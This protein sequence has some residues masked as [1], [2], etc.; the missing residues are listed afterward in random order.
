M[1]YLKINYEEV[2]ALRGLPHMQQLLYLCGIKPFVDYRTG[3][4]G[5]KR[6]ISYQS[7]S[8]VL[9]IEPHS[10]IQSGSP[11]KSQLRR[12]LKGLERAGV[13]KIQSDDYSLI[14]NCLLLS[15]G[16]SVP[17]KPVIK[18]SRE[19]VQGITSEVD[20]KSTT[21]K[22][23]EAKPVITKPGQ[24]VI[25]LCSNNN[26]LFL[27]SKQ[28][29]E[30]WKLYPLKK[31]KQKTWE[32][33]Q[34]MQPTDEQ[35]TCILVALEKQVTAHNHLTAQGQWVPGWKFPPNWLAQHCWEDEINTDTLQESKHANDQKRHTAT[36]PV[37]SFWDSCK[38][39][40]EFIGSDNSNIV[41]IGGFRKTEKSH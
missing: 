36:Q 8:E 14:F 13:I 16:Q 21:Y 18:P 6:K 29:E 24:P 12:A 37:D 20:L 33:F 2:S 28:C 27:L 3:V 30:F 17:N 38:G 26:Y 1:E 39:G 22:S 19:A 40:A 41:N 31:S 15:S 25:P 5:V 11:S 9:Y 4:V 35:V 10:G 7:L 23:I 34:S 32:Q